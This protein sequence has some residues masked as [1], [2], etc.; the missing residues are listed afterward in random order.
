M[1]FALIKFNLPF[2]EYEMYI[3]LLWLIY[4]SSPFIVLKSPSGGEIIPLL[5]PFMKGKWP[6]P[7]LINQPVQVCDDK[8]RENK[9]T[10]MVGQSHSQS[11][12]MTIWHFITIWQIWYFITIWHY[13]NLIFHHNLT[14][15][16]FHHKLTIW[17]IWYFI[18]IWHYD[19]MIFHHNL[20]NIISYH[21]L[22]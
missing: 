14:N 17:Q 9:Q 12:I 19:N 18:T 15:M 21:N 20:T 13:D 3:N 6:P 1:H 8:L 16:I 11:D 22:T 7:P 5:P 4:M 10:S 2:D